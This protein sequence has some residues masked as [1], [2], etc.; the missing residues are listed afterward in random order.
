MYIITYLTCN[1]S[2]MSNPKWLL[3]DEHEIQCFHSVFIQAYKYRCITH[4]LVLAL[5]S[6]TDKVNMYVLYDKI[7]LYLLI[8]SFILFFLNF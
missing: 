6:L 4:R 8:Y 3:Y 7:P 2:K 1:G 5:I